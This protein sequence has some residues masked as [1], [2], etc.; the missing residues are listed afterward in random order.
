MIY[1]LDNPKSYL[2]FGDLGPVIK[3]KSRQLTNESDEIYPEV[4]A[5]LPSNLQ[6]Y[7]FDTIPRVY[8]VLLTLNSSQ[9]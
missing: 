7:T 2:C 3:V 5:S 6:N 1:L 4:F 8:Y 9:R